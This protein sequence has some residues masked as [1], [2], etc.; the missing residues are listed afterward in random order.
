MVLAMLQQPE[1][2]FYNLNSNAIIKEDIIETDTF[3]KL[4]NQLVHINYL[5][6]NELLL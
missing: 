5:I 6:I 3:S 4:H 2:Y 1:T